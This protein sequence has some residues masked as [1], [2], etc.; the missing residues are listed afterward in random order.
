MG[1][2]S[3]LEWRPSVGPSSQL[4]ESKLHPPWTRPGIVPRTALV[5]RLLAESATPVIC[6]VA[7]PGYGK[8]TVL[9]QW[10][11]RR[12]RVGWVA[13]DRRDN[14]PM[15]LLTYV[16]A[17]L[18]RIEPIDPGIF[19]T[20][21]SPGVGVAAT[22]VPWLTTLAAMTEP[23]ALVLDNLDAL[24]EPECLDVVAELVAQFSARPPGGSQLV[25]ASRTRPRLP[26]ALLRAPDRIV[27]VGV[28][29]LAMNQREAS[30]LLEEAG[31]RL[32]EAETSELIRRTEGW[33]VGLYLA[34]LSL[35]AGRAGEE[36]RVTFAGDDRLVA[37]YL[38]SELLAR[39]APH[40]VSFLTRTAVLERMCGPLCDQVLDTEGSGDTLESL[41]DSNLLLIPLDQHREWYRYHHLFGDLLRAEL[42]RREPELVPQLHLRAAVWCEANGLE[43]TAVDHAQAAGD[44]D[45]VARLVASLA[46]PVTAA[47]QVDTARRWLAWFEGQELIERYPLVA[48]QGAWVHALWGHPAT[49]ERWADA[50]EHGSFAETVPDG[51][52]MQ[53]YRALLSALLC[54]GG[55]DQMRTDVD[56]ALSGLSP[57]SRW[58]TLALLLEGV[59]HLLD[60]KPDSADSVLADAVEAG[61]RSGALAGLA[62]A[63]A[64]RSLIAIARGDWHKAEALAE[65]AH[66]IVRANRLDDYIVI[67]LVYAVLARTAAHRGE[68]EQAQRHLARAARLRPH[69]TYAVPHLAVQT[70][71]ELSRAYLEFGDASGT[72][73]TLREAQDILRRRPGLGVLPEQVAKLRTKLDTNRDKIIGASSLTR[74]ELR[75]LPLLSTHFT[76]GE[77]GQRLYISPNTVKKHAQSVYQ[78]LDVSSRSQ[79]V[80]RARELGLSV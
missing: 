12:D 43:E 36:N 79:A 46:Q 49:A 60:G 3:Q 5:E 64:E 18:D 56:A 26:T 16:A 53:S 19:R 72:T 55:V 59:L 42:E 51:S 71:L 39:L 24:N 70:L 41:A 69:L 50:A 37:E 35:Q 22:V 38:W 10:A 2:N 20:L 48:L 29:E 76:F 23:S 21:A 40:E 32:A 74:A 31:L 13:V 66:T 80:Q 67:A 1:E 65:R 33:P 58:W 68:V 14:D 27:E 25:L 44:I 30:T 4:L 28:D 75:V 8:T 47:G 63:L 34:A 52:T 6:V 15:V 7:P 73:A 77:I 62:V 11:Q 9:A 45:R 17:A 61:T 57:S 54:R 78:K